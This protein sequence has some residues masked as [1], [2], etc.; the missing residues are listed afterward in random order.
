MTNK[1]TAGDREL[2]AELERL[3]GR[4]IRSR[5][6]IAAYVAELSQRAQDKHSKWQ[7]FKNAAL[8]GLLVI[9]V[10]QY[11]YLD[12]ALEILAQPTLTVFVPA[13]LNPTKPYL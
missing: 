12:V 11:Y 7:G 9:A 3:S 6:D 13:S 4:Q 10:L 1:A 8:G 5:E 2:V